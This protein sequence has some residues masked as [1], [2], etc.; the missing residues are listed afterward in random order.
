VPEDVTGVDTYHIVRQIRCE[1]RETIREFV[2][3]WLESLARDHESQPADP[4]AQR[5]LLQ[6]ESDPDSIRNFHPNLFPGPK[7]VQVRA[8]INS[9]YEAGIAYNFDMTMTEDNDLTTDIGF[10]KPLTKPKVT[11]GIGAGAKRKRSNNR[12]FTVTDTF[13]NLLTKV[14]TPVRG[15]RYC[16]GQ[17]VQ[18]NYIYPIA[19]RIGVDKLVKT[20]IELTLFANLAGSG[21]KPGA[22]G[23]PTIADKLTFTTTI[24]AS[25]T[26]KV[27]FTP[28]TDTFQLASASLTASAVR[29]DVHQVTV[30][31]AIAAGGV[32]ALD[33]FRSYLFSTERTT[34]A[35][36]AAATAQRAEPASTLV[37]GRRVTGGGT[38]SEMLAVIA[39]DQLKSRELEIIP[40]P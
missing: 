15:K 37:V 38:P 40:A 34:G 16:D 7:Y 33:P 3:T 20:F 2:I 14:N 8:L 21:A 19:G 28:V 5:L 22:G 36:G 17:I 23:A 11:V 4:I 6:Y 30:A 24:N 26:P 27:E 29:S 12:T 25:T 35:P 9:F 39:I 1:T 32:V 18:A 13:S 10:L 31:L